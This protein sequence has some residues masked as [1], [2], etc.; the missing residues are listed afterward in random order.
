MGLICTSIGKPYLFDSHVLCVTLRGLF[1]HYV[2]VTGLSLGTKAKFLNLG[3]L[4][5]RGGGGVHPVAVISNLVFIV[6]ILI[7]VVR[8]KTPHYSVQ[9]FYY[10]YY[11]LL[12]V[13]YRAQ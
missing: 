12:F 1:H 3:A 10:Y 4:V 9:T 8:I 7:K 6:V 2:L 5:K 13:P 11:C